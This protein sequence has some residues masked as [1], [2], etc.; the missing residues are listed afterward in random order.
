MS[1][2]KLFIT[3]HTIKIGAVTETL[4]LLNKFQD[5]AVRNQ[6]QRGRMSVI[7]CC[8]ICLVLV[9]DGWVYS[10]AKKE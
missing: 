5:F 1:L 2:S 6:M 3:F 4:I 9:S 8:K 7:L 10:K